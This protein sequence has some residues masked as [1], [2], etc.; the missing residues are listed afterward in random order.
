[1]AE[2]NRLVTIGNRIYDAIN[3]SD[4][5]YIEALGV[6]EIVKTHIQGRLIT[7]CQK[8]DIMTFKV[9]P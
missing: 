1:M 8:P 4:L 7:Q 3:D 5:N 9:K 2:E 6:L